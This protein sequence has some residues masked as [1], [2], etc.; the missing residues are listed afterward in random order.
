M[1]SRE[2]KYFSVLSSSILLPI[3]VFVTVLL[4]F[5]YLF[6]I[7]PEESTSAFS[8]LQLKNTEKPDLPS[9][10]PIGEKVKSSVSEES[11]P[12]PEV[13]TPACEVSTPVEQVRSR[14]DEVFLNL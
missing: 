11:T 10:E 9:E 14:L 12:I 6:Q 1:L 13:S 7:S 3:T 2:S 4:V 5:C 8:D